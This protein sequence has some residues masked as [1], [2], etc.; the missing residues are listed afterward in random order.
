MPGVYEHFPFTDYH[1]L[2]LSWVIEE[3]KRCVALCEN[4]DK[5]IDAKVT[6]I[7]TE[8]L[9]DGTI[10]DL[11]NVTI[12]SDLSDRVTACEEKL[13][14]MADT[15]RLVN[16]LKLAPYI[17]DDSFS[18]DTQGMCADTDTGYL[19]VWEGGT[20]PNGTLHVY[21]TATMSEVQT[22]SNVAAY[23]C[24]DM[25]KVG[26]LIYI[27]QCYGSGV[28]VLD[29]NNLL[30]YN[31]SANS[32]ATIRSFPIAAI[33]GVA[34]IDDD[35]LLILGHPGGSPATVSGY[36][37]FRYDTAANAYVLIGLDVSKAP[38]FSATH[39]TYFDQARG[40]YHMLVSGPD[41]I[42]S[43]RFK[44][45]TLTYV[46]CTKLSK[47]DYNGINIGEYEALA[48]FDGGTNFY[49]SHQFFNSN[50]QDYTFAIGSINLYNGYPEFP[51][52]NNWH[53]ILNTDET[54]YCD[55]TATALYEDG[56]AS[57][58]FKALSRAV[59]ALNF[60]GRFKM[61]S[62]VAGSFG[63]VE[64]SDRKVYI[65]M[66]GPASVAFC[67]MTNCDVSIVGNASNYLTVTQNLELIDCIGVITFATFERR[68]IFS[69][70]RQFDLL[71]FTSTYASY[72]PVTATES[73][74][75]I[76]PISC[77]TWNNKKIWLQAFSIAYIDQSIT[78]SEVY[79]EGTN[80]TVIRSGSNIT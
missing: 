69:R 34:A 37:F 14:A 61:I 18:N 5:E 25:T 4:V 22:I 41:M 43:F 78:T 33:T 29:G 2:N 35:N 40:L 9:D 19:Y 8:W 65:T 63:Q 17:Y 6:A 70:C 36:T 74:I 12:F 10:A 51:L 27:A 32:M 11:I 48:S 80:W 3:V 59:E 68:V 60:A 20:F 52:P 58:P 16:E 38:S 77:A 75:R 1:E 45:D 57:Y 21:D 28:G 56:T 24:N 54:A 31:I 49:V 30:A 47:R 62:V 26:N 50:G 76:H 55:G 72:Y 44:E 13:A 15:P 66:A 53:S 23:H 73:F 64:I 39:G 79:H 67:R 71:D 42:L 7:L 46:S